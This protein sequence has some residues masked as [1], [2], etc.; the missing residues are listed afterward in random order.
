MKNFAQCN[1]FRGS[2]STLVPIYNASRTIYNVFLFIIE[3]FQLTSTARPRN[4][5]QAIFN[6]RKSRRR[7]RRLSPQEH[8]GNKGKA[9]TS[10]WDAAAAVAAF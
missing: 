4:Q 3:L 10:D 8:C 7:C 2:R 9:R 6:A 1:P 5:P